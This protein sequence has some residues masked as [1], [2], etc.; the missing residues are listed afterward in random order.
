[1]T[2]LQTIPPAKGAVPVLGHLPRLMRD[3]L[4]VLRSLHAEGDILVLRAGTMPMVYVTSPEL[5]NQVMVQRARSFRKGRLFD[6]AR[7]LVGDGIANSEGA[8]HIRNRRLIQPMF[9]KER[10]AG[11][12]DLMSARAQALSDSWRPGMEVDATEAM[13]RL[14]IEILADTL[15]SHDISEQAVRSVQEDLPVIMRNVLRR[16]LAPQFMD[17]WPI[18]SDFNRASARMRAVIDEVIVKTRA[19]GPEDRSD[20]LS[21]LLAVKDDEG[22]GFTD[23]EIRDELTTFLF[24]GTETPASVLA[25][26]LHHLSEE[27]DIERAVLDEIKEVVG[28]RPVDFDDVMRLPTLTRVLDESLRLHGVVTL[29]RRSTEPVTLGGHEIPAETEVLIS[30]YALH[31]HPELYPDPERFDPDRWLPERVA[32]RPREHAV[33]FGAGNRR[34]IGDKFGWMEGVIALTTLLPRWKLAPNPQRKAPRE[35]TASM[36]MPTRVDLVVHPR[37]AA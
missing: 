6:R 3:P 4:G 14:A 30:L 33:P 10:L 17:S 13:S 1:M 18:W 36:A 25:W 9:Y 32:A 23:D 2:S 21:L 22:V 16:A 37:D 11:Y 12:A 26:A 31:R 7:L 29:M 20:M 28:D 34:C 15:F 35:A 27:P 19:S 5:V 8:K 24:A